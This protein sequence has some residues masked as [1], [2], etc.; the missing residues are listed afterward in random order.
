MRDPNEYYQLVYCHR[1]PYR[2]WRR[3]IRIVNGGA[4]I[5]AGE[6][7]LPEK[8]RECEAQAGEVF[9]Y[10][11]AIMIRAALSQHGCVYCNSTGLVVCSGCGRILCNL[12]QSTWLK[13][14]WCQSREEGDIVDEDF[15]PVSRSGYTAWNKGRKLM[16]A[17]GGAR[18]LRAGAPLSH[19]IGGS[20]M[21]EFE[22]PETVW[23]PPATDQRTAAEKQSDNKL[24]KWLED[25][26]PKKN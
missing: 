14:H 15:M 24:L 3:Q 9:V 21:P 2:V 26:R 5:S 8:V 22:E 4:V 10:R 16:W 23:E 12:P 20:A 17:N 19:E 18:E 1:P 25:K 6:I 11:G 13:C 7:L